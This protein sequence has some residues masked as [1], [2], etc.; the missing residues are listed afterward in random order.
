MPFG[1]KNAGA[2]FQRLV[3]EMFAKKL[4]KTIEVYIDDMLV[5][6]LKA[7]DHIAHLGE[8]LRLIREYCMRLNPKKCV[9]AVVSGRFL[10]VVVTMRGIEA[11]PE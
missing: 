9:F 11:S 6:S 10:V 3:N 8:C 4:G 2:T 7:E 1:L 5:K